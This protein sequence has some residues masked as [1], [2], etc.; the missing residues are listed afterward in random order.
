MILAL[1][2]TLALQSS[3]PPG[4][5]PDPASIQADLAAQDAEN[6]GVLVLSRF[7]GAAREL[8]GAL[9]VNP[10]DLDGVADAIA[11]ASTMP[12]AERRER[13]QSMMQHLREHDINRWRRDYLHAL[14]ADY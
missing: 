8:N 5:P 7:A 14:E 13:W 1:L 9:L 4:A 11:R 6:P 12:L 2:A 10:Y 3:S